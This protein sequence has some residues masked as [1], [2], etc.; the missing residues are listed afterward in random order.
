MKFEY[1]ELEQKDV[2]NAIE[3]A[4]NHYDIPPMGAICDI[5]L[6]CELLTLVMKKI[7]PEAKLSKNIL[8]MESMELLKNGLRTSQLIRK[9]IEKFIDSKDKKK[10]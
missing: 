6:A 8:G 3:K 9:E 4:L 7:D 10:D 2:H 5:T 1:F